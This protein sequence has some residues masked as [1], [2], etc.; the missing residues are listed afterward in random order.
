MTPKALNT[1]GI[2]NTVVLVVMLGLVW[3]KVVPE[4]TYP[5]IFLFA[6]ALVLM[7]FTIRLVLQRNQRKFDEQKKPPTSPT[8]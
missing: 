5:T 2:V 6:A 3:F 8:P 4:S 7:R 1:Y